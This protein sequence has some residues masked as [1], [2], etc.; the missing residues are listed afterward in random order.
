ML[1]KHSS[2][3]VNGVAKRYDVLS[4]ERLPRKKGGI[5]DESSTR[6]RQPDPADLKSFPA[7]AG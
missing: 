3:L 1:A 6:A 7:A 2:G 5:S 4:G